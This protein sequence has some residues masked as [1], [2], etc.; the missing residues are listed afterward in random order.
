MGKKLFMLAIISILSL[1]SVFSYAQNAT[2]RKLVL[3]HAQERGNNTIAVEAY[4]INDVLEVTVYARMYATKPKIFNAILVGPKLG[5]LSPR[6]R[7]TLYPQAE[8]VEKPFSTT[9]VEGGII[10]F[11]KRTQDKIAKGTLTKE[12]INFKIPAGKIMLNRR[13]ELRIKVESMQ[14]PGQPQS[15][16]FQLKDF[17][18]FFHK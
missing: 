8:D 16:V 13:Y 9:D 17:P 2:E 12:L 14:N 15:F 4:L 3:R 1:V 10:R 11:S 5:R 7:K 6:S 18:Q